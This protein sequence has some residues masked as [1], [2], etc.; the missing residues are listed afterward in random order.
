MKAYDI[1]KNALQLLGY[2]AA[3][4]NAQLDSRLKTKAVPVVNQVY[5]D[6]WRICKEG[7]FTPI[8]SLQEEIELPERAVN[9]AVIYG[10][11]MF[12]AQSESDGDTQQLYSHLYNKK[13][14]SLSRLETVEDRL[15]RG[16][17][18]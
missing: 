12:M 11:C 4:G 10:V 1:V 18:E 7:E 6:L 8:K 16:V 13:R 5:S 17:D 9:D 15:A 2:T 3:D 14:A